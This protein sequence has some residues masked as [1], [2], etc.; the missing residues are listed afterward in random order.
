LSQITKAGVASNKV[1]VGVSSYGRSFAMA[2]ADCYTSD[3]LYTG[4]AAVSNA[5]EGRCTATAGYISDAEIYDI[6]NNNSSRVNQNFVDSTSNSRIV[7]YDSTQWVAFMDGDIRSQR[8][9]LYA[10]LHMGGTTNWASDLEYFNDAPDTTKSWDS[11][12]LNIN[13]GA[14]PYAEGDRHGNWTKLLCDDPSVAGLRVFM[15]QQR[16][17]MM[18]AP[19]A[20]ADVIN[21]YKTYDQPVHTNFTA[22]V[23][24]TIHGPENAD[25]GLLLNT[26]NCEQTV[27][28]NQ[29]QGLTPA[30]YEIWNS[31]VYIHEVRF[32][33]N[34]GK[35]V[36]AHAPVEFR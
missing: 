22:S 5:A 29:F 1:I 20:W 15:P 25:C 19:D 28:C 18:D 10:E 9:A 21:V 8:S 26:N 36:V 16:W 12:K 24:N 17:N 23:S 35:Y 27:M 31:M 32:R 3:C 33:M 30:G 4:S 11:F 2:E 13:T 34:R 7:V 14:D 6:V